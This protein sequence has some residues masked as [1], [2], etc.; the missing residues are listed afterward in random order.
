MHL[1]FLSSPEIGGRYTLSPG[2][3]IAAKYLATRLEA[4]GYKGPVKGS[5]Y[6]AFDLL[7]AEPQPERCSLELEVDGQQTA[8][9]YGTFYNNGQVEGEVEGPIVFVGRGI[10]SKRL[11]HDDYENLDVRGKIVLVA[12]GAPPGI[13]ADA[14]L[15]SEE[16]DEAAS[17]HGAVAVFYIPAR[18]YADQMRSGRYRDRSSERAVLAAEKKT[19]IPEIRLGIEAAEVLLKTIGLSLQDVHDGQRQR[20]PLEPKA[21]PARAKLALKLTQRLRQAQNVVGILEGSDPK[22]KAEYISFSA[23]YDHLQTNREGKYYPGADDDGSGTTAVLAIAKAVAQSKPKRSTLIIFHA[24]EEM[25]LLGSRYNADIAPIVPP[26]RLTVN[27]NMDMIGRNRDDQP[28]N[29][30]IVDRNSIYAIGADK[31]SRQLHDIHE[32]TNKEFTKL[33]LDYKLNDPNHPDRFY[34]RSDHW[35]Y[36]KHNVPIIFWFDGVGVDYHQPTDTVDKIDF[37]KMARVAT[38]AYA[39]GY[40]VGNLDTRLKV[41]AEKARA[42][43]AG[44]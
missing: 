39:T 14:I 21:T 9:K 44:D 33:N 34:F 4:Y 25:G 3:Q 24:G 10:S 26:E 20:R 35:N 27:L 37:E 31:L 29:A 15:D 23:H 2:L 16:D 17:A 36:A 38:L 19:R 30:E 18:Y 12:A 41:D 5:F 13:S 1:E 8:Y 6:Q 28:G 11:K 32:R 40:R 43:A 7:T 22:L 42:R